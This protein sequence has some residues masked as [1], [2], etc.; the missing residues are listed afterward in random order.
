MA[1]DTSGQWWVGSQPGDIGGFLKAY[2]SPGYAVDEFRLS[3]CNCGCD[4]FNLWADDDDGCARRECLSCRKATFICDSEEYWGEAAPV[5]WSCI[6]CGEQAEACNIGVGFSLYADDGEIR[7]LYL[8]VRCA[9]CGILGCFA[10]W[11]IAYAPSRHLLE[12]I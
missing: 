7:W 10:G 12:Q 11:K 8:G 3:F 6:E 5:K 2:A 4:T 9:L 1:L